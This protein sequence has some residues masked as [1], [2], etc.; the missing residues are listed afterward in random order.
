MHICVI[1]GS[2]P[3][4]GLPEY[5]F[6]EQLCLAWVRSGHKVSVIVPQSITKRLLRNRPKLPPVREQRGVTVYSPE[7]FSYGNKLKQLGNWNFRTAVTKSIL[8]LPA[9]PDIIYG[10]FWHNAFAGF[11]A[12]KKLNLPLFVASGESEIDQRALTKREKEFANYVS[13]VV[14]V[15]TK[16]KEESTRL[17]L[18]NGSNCIV[19]PNAIDATLFHA[20]DK[21]EARK[22]LKLPLDDFIVAFVGGFIPRKGPDRVAKAISQIEKKD[23]KSIF[24]GRPQDSTNVEPECDG[25]LYK[26]P[27]PHEKVPAYLR[28]ADVFVLPTLHEGCCNAIVEAMAC[29]LPVIS[30]DRPFN[31]DVCTPDNSILVDPMDV[32]QIAEAVNGLHK[33]SEL[34]LNM[35]QAALSTASS[36]EINS[37]ASKII[38]FINE[39]TC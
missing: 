39:K 9:T 32:K 13:G 28:A 24:I 25:I 33:L 14:C 37:R 8:Q 27:L 16:N 6:V 34:R 11:S 17:G 10:H 19:L 21:Q 23:I 7:F 4:P 35:A 36:L 3:S 12:A 38:E 5:P 22:K 30:S 2:Y 26:G 1:S 29:G 31:Y 15:S 20:G 18:T